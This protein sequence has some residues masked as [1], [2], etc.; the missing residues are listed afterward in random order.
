[1]HRS[2]EALYETCASCRA[3]VLPTE[4]AFAFEGE[5]GEVAV[6]CFA[7]GLARGGVHDERLDRWEHPPDVADLIA[8]R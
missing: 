1:M 8:R 3:D 2:E 7:C 5:A 6:L 4:R